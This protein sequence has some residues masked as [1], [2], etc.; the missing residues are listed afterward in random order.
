MAWHRFPLPPHRVGNYKAILTVLDSQG[1]KARPLLT[2][3]SP[4]PAIS[5]G[6]RP[7][8]RSFQLIADKKS[9][10]P[11][12]TAHIL[13]AQPFQGE[14]YALLTLERGHIYEKKVIKLESNST[15]YDLPI[16]ADMAPIMYLSSAWSKGQTGST[17]PISRS[18]WPAWPSIPASR[19]SMLLL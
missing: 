12:D 17:H 10:Q 2:C 9:Y 5:P 4:V 19:T 8:T 14:V 6:S 15:I 16:T 7:T 11:G 1:R 18:A 3:G 13:I